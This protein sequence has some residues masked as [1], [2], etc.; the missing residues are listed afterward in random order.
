MLALQ[1][2]ISLPLCRPSFPFYAPCCVHLT[3][4]TQKLLPEQRPLHASIFSFLVPLLAGWS[5]FTFPSFTHTARRR[6]LFCHTP[7]ILH[8][9]SF[10]YRRA[11]FVSRVAKLPW[12]SSLASF[13]VWPLSCIEFG[14]CCRSCSGNRVRY[15]SGWLALL[16][17]FCQRLETSGNGHSIEAATDSEREN[18]FHCIPFSCLLSLTP[19]KGGGGTYAPSFHKSTSNLFLK[20]LCFSSSRNKHCIVYLAKQMCQHYQRP[21]LPRTTLPP[22]DLRRVPGNISWKGRHGFLGGRERDEGQ[23]QDESEG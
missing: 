18:L 15:L 17:I 8:T 5:L 4:Q 23:S 22:R 11:S 21:L 14:C 6:L 13:E 10:D 16:T 7:P 3:S 12:P 2:P 19:K 1:A 9:Y 20:I